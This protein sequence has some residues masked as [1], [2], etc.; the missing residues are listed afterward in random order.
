MMEVSFFSLKNSKVLASSNGLTSFFLLNFLIS[1]FLKLIKSHIA[2]CKILL[3]VDPG[4]NNA[5][6]VFSTNLASR[7]SMA[8]L[9]RAFF[10]L[11]VLIILVSL[12]S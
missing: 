10:G 4:T 7:L 11:T 8:L 2:S 6:L 1:G 9:D 12:V 3:L 5:L